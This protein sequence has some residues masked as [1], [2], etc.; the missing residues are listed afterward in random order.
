VTKKIVVILAGGFAKRLGEKSANTPKVLLPIRGIPFL[1]WK[2]DQLRK[3]NFNHL[4]LSVHHLSDQIETWVEKEKYND[5]KITFSYDGAIPLGT[6]G[7]IK[8]IAKE[9]NQKILLTYG[10]SYSP[11]GYSNFFDDFE[12]RDTLASMMVYKNS[13]L[14][15]RSNIK[16]R[17]G[18]VTNYNKNGNLDH[19][20]EYIDH[21]ATIF[22][23]KIFEQYT[24]PEVF[25]LSLVF[26]K[27]I[28][29]KQVSGYIESQRFYEIGSIS[30]INDFENYLS[31]IES[32][33]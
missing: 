16:V 3:E 10:D 4:V 20:L 13:N 18:L 19:L 24:F 32:K 30:G 27:L 5:I 9:L 31:G 6:G 29:E 15:D 7:A 1:K 11:S 14:Y 12:S 2:I 21:G 17:N 22:N 8:K 23:P 26:E 28:L 25:D 33:P